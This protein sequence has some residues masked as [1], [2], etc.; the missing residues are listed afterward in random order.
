MSSGL[1]S[2]FD[3]ASAVCLYDVLRFEIT[4][5]VAESIGGGDSVPGSAVQQAV[6]QHFPFDVRRKDTEDPSNGPNS[7]GCSSGTAVD[8]EPFDLRFACDCS[9]TLFTGENCERAPVPESPAPVPPMA[10]PASAG[11]NDNASTA[12]VALGVVLGVVFLFLA[13]G[14]VLYWHRST[15]SKRRR[16]DFSAEIERMLAAGELE[17]EQASDERVPREIKRS[18][19]KMSEKLGEGEF[20]EVWKAVL[21][22]SKEG[23]VPAYIAA[24]KL[25]PDPMAPDDAIRDLYREATVM[26]Q[27][28][29]HDNV[30]SLIGAVTRCVARHLAVWKHGPISSH[31]MR[32]SPCP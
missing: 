2:H 9:R 21:D 20:G 8:S 27:V 25:V 30:L 28:T 4:L 22:E 19:V 1:K 23:G 26:A 15:A 12:N 7:K 10:P 29:G 18:C 13:I 32:S 3:P 6:L 5:S 11:G 14:A 16:H 31:S 24:A 17:P